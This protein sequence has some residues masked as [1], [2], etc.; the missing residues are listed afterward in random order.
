MN[1]SKKKFVGTLVG[2]VLISILLTSYVWASAPSNRYTISYGVYPG[3]PS[4]TVYQVAGVTYAKDQNGYNEFNGTNAATVI[5]SALSGL[6]SGRTWQERVLLKGTFTIYQTI[7]I[8]SYTIFQLDG[9]IIL[10]SPHS[11]TPTG[12]QFFF[13][14]NTHSPVWN[15]GSW[16]PG[17]GDTQIAI[18]GGTYDAVTKPTNVMGLVLGGCTDSSIHDTTVANFGETGIVV[19]KDSSRV[20]VHHNWVWNTGYDGIGTGGFNSIV[21]DV[22]ITDNWIN[23]STPHNGIVVE[24]Q[25]YNI[26]IVNNHITGAVL[27]GIRIEGAYNILIQGN[28]ISG[29]GEDGV[30]VSDM[31]GY[32]SY[33]VKVLNNPVIA[34]NGRDG[35]NIEGLL[36]A[37]QYVIVS[38]NTI[39]DNGLTSYA[40]GIHLNASYSI[41]S[42][43]LVYDNAGYQD[44][45]IYADGGIYNFIS[46]CITRNNIIGGIYTTPTSAEVTN[47][48]NHTDYIDH[49]PL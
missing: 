8:P 9:S 41:V 46:D 33:G 22:W 10:G 48:F 16:I 30:Y 2:I 39:A 26:H 28:Y 1:I 6:T 49:S 13:I 12:G 25:N 35:V 7:F 27:D 34:G 19:M 42:N 38:G 20:F 5:N 37:N 31:N 17:D 4:Y 43:N 45:G 21:H 3:A 14:V 36:L 18:I 44:W 32:Q 15:G 24:Q 11:L 40:S 23:G 29:N 47:S